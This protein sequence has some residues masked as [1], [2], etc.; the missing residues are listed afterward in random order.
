[1]LNVH[2]NNKLQGAFLWWATRKNKMCRKFCPFCKY[3]F[4]CQEDVALKNLIEGERKDVR[5]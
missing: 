2:H 3:Y 5:K 4:R 1:M